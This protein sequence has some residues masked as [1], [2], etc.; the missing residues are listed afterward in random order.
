MKLKYII[1]IIAAGFPF[2]YIP[3]KWVLHET[4]IPFRCLYTSEYKNENKNIYSIFNLTQ[5][6]RVNSEKEAYFHVDGT[7][8][9]NNMHYRVARTLILR[10]GSLLEGDS[11][12]F[13]D[14]KTVISP[15]D[16]VPEDLINEVFQEYMTTPYSFQIDI[17]K[18]HGNTY[19]LGGAYSYISTCLRY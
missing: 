10:N 2:L 13:D 19:L 16:N 8:D 6:L 12:R 18:L 4:P 3:L 11:L 9:L 17:D 5:D 15:G 1:I 14:I 7:A